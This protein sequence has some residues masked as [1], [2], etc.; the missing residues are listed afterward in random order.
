MMPDEYGS[1]R[2]SG[3][4]MVYQIRITGHLGQQW[5]DWFEGLTITLEE[6]GST[7]L[8]GPVIDQAALHGILKKIR[9]LGMPLLS[10]HSLEACPQDRSDVKLLDVKKQH[11]NSS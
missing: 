3:Q 6:D 8:S 1:E 10:V 2:T 5:V 7:L 9:D 4:S 11:D